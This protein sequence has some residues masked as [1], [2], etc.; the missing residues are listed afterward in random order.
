MASAL[1]HIFTAV[2]YEDV[3]TM[4]WIKRIQVL[5]PKIEG[6]VLSSGISQ[7]VVHWKSTDV[8]EEHITSIFRNQHEAELCLLPASGCFIAWL[9]LGPWRWRW[10]VTPKRRLT[11]NGIYGVI[12]QKIGLFITSALRTSN[13]TTS[14]AFYCLLQ[15]N[16]WQRNGSNLSP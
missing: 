12:S 6:I 7:H 2:E 9:T 16:Y 8:S 13:P 3:Q 4:W 5:C 10:Y 11:F 14:K 1:H 15:P